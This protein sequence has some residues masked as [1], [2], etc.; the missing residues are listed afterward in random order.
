MLTK[1]NLAILQ[2]TKNSSIRST[3]LSKP[4]PGMK[5][6]QL[7]AFF[8]EVGVILGLAVG[9]ESMLE[10]ITNLGPLCVCKT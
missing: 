3:L 5:I 9:T 10:Q 8:L 6:I 7:T 1:A 4:Q 2:V